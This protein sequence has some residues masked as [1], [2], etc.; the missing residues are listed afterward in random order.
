MW[1]SLSNND[2]T[3]AMQR[4]AVRNHTMLAPSNPYVL[5]THKKFTMTLPK[6]AFARGQFQPIILQPIVSVSFYQSL[7]FKNCPPDCVA[8]CLCFYLNR[9]FI[10]VYQHGYR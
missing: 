9:L 5:L 6:I 8:Y 10:D 3:T 7:L 2:F 1:T 4:K